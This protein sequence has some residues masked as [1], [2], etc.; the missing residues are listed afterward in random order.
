MIVCSVIL[1][2]RIITHERANGRQSNMVGVVKGR[3]SRS[4]QLLF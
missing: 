4:D 2:V 1:S 3:P